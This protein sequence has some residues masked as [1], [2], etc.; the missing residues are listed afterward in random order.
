MFFVFQKEIVQKEMDYQFRM[1]AE[2]QEKQQICH[3][4]QQEEYFEKLDY[5]IT[6]KL[7][8]RIKRTV[9]I[10]HFTGK[11]KKKKKD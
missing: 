3:Q 9:G 8:N 6:D 4:K 1:V 2:E 7:Q 5:M 11:E 10:V